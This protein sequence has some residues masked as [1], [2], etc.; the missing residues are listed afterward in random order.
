MMKLRLLV[1]GVCL[2]VAL[3]ISV[4][5]AA[6]D[7]TAGPPICAGPA[8]GVTPISGKYRNLTITGERYVPSG[9]VLE[10]RRESDYRSGELPR[11]VHAGNRHRRR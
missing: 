10:V 7:P 9:T 1:G 4:A 3:A 11:R 2:V 5:P 6:A 8:S